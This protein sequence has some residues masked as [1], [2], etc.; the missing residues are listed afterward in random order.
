[1]TKL[2]KRVRHC[3][4]ASLMGGKAFAEKMKSLKQSENSNQTAII[5]TPPPVDPSVAII[6]AT[7]DR[8][9]RAFAAALRHKPRQGEASVQIIDMNS[10]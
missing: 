7:V 1:M 9:I 6:P 3:R 2:S 10:S 5:E 8:E 4:A